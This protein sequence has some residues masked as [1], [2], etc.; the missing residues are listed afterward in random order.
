MPVTD[1]MPSAAMAMPYKPANVNAPMMAS[2]RMIAGRPV[3]YI[4]TPR[5]AMMLVAAPVTDASVM[6]RTG[7]LSVDV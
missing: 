4:P 5:P 6:A 2:A 3:E 7:A 1:N